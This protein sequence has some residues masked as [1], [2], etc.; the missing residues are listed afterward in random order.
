MKIIAFVAYLLTL[1]GIA[2]QIPAI[3]NMDKMGYP[4]IL[5]SFNMIS[6]QFLLKYKESNRN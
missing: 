4:L 5:I 1:S 3:A 2:L 6:I